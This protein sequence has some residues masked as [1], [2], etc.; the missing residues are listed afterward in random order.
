M[1]HGRDQFRVN[2]LTD[3]GMNAASAVAVTLRMDDTDNTDA[4]Q[5]KADASHK[6]KA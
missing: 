3:P 5:S 4:S 1:C 2:F 6:I